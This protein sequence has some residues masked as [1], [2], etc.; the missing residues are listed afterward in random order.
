MRGLSVNGFVIVETL[1]S[2]RAG[3]LYLARHPQTGQEAIIRLAQTPE[4]GLSAK[5]FLEEATSLLPSATDVEASTASDGSPVLV[6]RPPNPVPPGAGYTAHASTVK[7]P[8]RTSPARRFAP[9]VVL[10]VGLLALA[11]GVTLVVLTSQRAAVPAPAVTAPADLTRD[12]DDRSR[13]PAAAQRQS[14]LPPVAPTPVVVTQPPVVPTPDSLKQARPEPGRAAA[15]VTCTPDERWRR[16]M[17]LN[18]REL[19]ARANAL[20]PL[21]VEREVV[22]LGAAVEAASTAAECAAVTTRFDALV[23]RALRASP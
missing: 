8:E 19:E 3:N 5:V 15:V 13:E 20:E 10:F 6:A 11:M 7:L 22:R 23:K 1:G 14:H 12:V 4:D 21:E 9:L 16:A 18:L 17:Q 2:G